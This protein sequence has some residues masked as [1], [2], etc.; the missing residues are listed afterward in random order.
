MDKRRKGVGTGR[1]KVHL[2]TKQNEKV[3]TDQGEGSRIPGKGTRMAIELD[4]K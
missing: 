4:T 3:L 1:L 2:K